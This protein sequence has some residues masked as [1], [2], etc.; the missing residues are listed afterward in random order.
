MGRE[1]GEKGGERGEVGGGEGAEGIWGVEER[2]GGRERVGRAGD[3]GSGGRVTEGDDGVEP[4][5][6]DLHSGHVHPVPHIPLVPAP[7]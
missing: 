7:A 3:E 5:G 1:E 6:A 2:E 4:R